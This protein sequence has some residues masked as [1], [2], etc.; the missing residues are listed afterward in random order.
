[1]I[2]EISYTLFTETRDR[3]YLDRLEKDIRKINR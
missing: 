3:Q 2:R 1:M